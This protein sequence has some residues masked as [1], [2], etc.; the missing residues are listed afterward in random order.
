MKKQI[1]ISI[2]I[3]FLLSFTFAQINLISAQEWPAFNVC[4][5]K[6][7]EGAF[8]QNALEENCDLSID[9]TK[10]QPFRMTPT[11][12]E[13]TSFCRLG[14]CID[15]AEGLCCFLLIFLPAP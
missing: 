5:E 13:A 11:S 12:C 7:N 6:T 3:V 2:I 15:S 1:I 10:G 14:C 4:C 8:C 9:P